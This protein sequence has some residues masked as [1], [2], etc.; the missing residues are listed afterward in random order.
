M[1]GPTRLFRFGIFELDPEARKLLKRGAQSQLQEQPFQVLVMLLE[2]AGAIVTRDDIRRRLWSP[3][4]FVNFEQGLGTAV[5]KIRRALGDDADLPRYI[6]TIPRR[7]YRF[8]APV[9]RISELR[10]PADLPPAGQLPSM[11]KSTNEAANRGTPIALIL[12]VMLLVGASVCLWL[13]THLLTKKT[14]T[15]SGQRVS[16]RP[17]TRTGN[18]ET[19]AISP[20]GSLVAYVTAAEGKPTLLLRQTTAPAV[21]EVTPALPV[22]YWGLTFSRDGSFLYVVRS[23]EGEPAA[24]R[25]WRVPLFG[26]SSVELANAVDSPVAVSPDGKQIAFVRL[27]TPGA[28]ESLIVANAD[29]SGQ[30]PLIEGYPLDLSGA[31]WSPDG[32]LI[33]VSCF[34]RHYGIA[35]VSADHGVIRHLESNKYAFV[36]KVAWLSNSR[37]AVTAADRGLT[38]YQLWEID[39][40]SGSVKRVT[41]DAT[42]YSALSATSDGNGLLA[43]QRSSPTAIWIGSSP[44]FR[45]MREVVKD[46]VDYDFMQAMIWTPGGHLLY[47]SKAAGSLDIWDLDPQTRRAFPIVSDGLAHPWIS[48]GSGGRAVILTLGG[49]A[50]NIERLDLANMSRSP[51]AS[52]PI[53]GCP[54][55]SPDDKTVVYVGGNDGTALMTVSRVA[56]SPVQLAGSAQ[57]FPRISPDSRFVAYNRLEANAKRV[58][59]VV[60]PI[61]GGGAVATLDLPPDSEW[62]LK[63]DFQWSPDGQALTYPVTQDGVSNI[64]RMSTRGGPAVQLTHFGSDRVFS[65]AWSRDGRK[66]AVVRGARSSDLVEIRF[67][68]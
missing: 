37:L 57:C 38:G 62:Q 53:G 50:H 30:H 51:V 9:E 18:V 28:G 42:D 21:T 33:A 5:K 67:D 48:G 35:I 45:D 8:I 12:S 10:E 20:D 68:K 52:T 25:L 44:D 6:E 17:L 39:Y 43:V 26:G 16:I 24:H 4:T 23:E 56:S 41:N 22:H 63:R 27:G 2:N 29:G 60:I 32:R 40:P 7:G 15:A 14:A 1:P 54:D 11:P 55:V 58:R 3:D 36:R 61:T 47:S 31:S 66:L 46:P 64:W 34:L 65:F 49:E 19:A 59:E 13:G